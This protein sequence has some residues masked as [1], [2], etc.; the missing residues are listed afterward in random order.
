MAKRVKNR[1]KKIKELR[2]TKSDLVK[3][4]RMGEWLAENECEGVWKSKSKVHKD[5]SKYNRKEKHSGNY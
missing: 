4:N 2:I 5:K 3:A 1:K